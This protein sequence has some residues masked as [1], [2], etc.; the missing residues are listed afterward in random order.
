MNLNHLNLAV[1]DVAASRDF[2]VRFFGM[3]CTETK[4]DNVL[5]VLVDDSGFILIFSNFQKDVSPAYP[6]DFHIGFLLDRVEVVNELYE[7]MTRAG[8]EIRPPKTAHGSWGFYVTAPGGITVE[9]SS[10]E[11]GA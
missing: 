9:V 7:T 10:Y 6:R 5:S 1:P 8:V 4:G 3:R 2:F 11:N